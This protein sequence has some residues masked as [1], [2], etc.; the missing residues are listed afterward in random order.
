V[1]EE[2]HVAA[3]GLGAGVHLA[4]AAPAGRDHP[5]LWHRA[6]DGLGR[7]V[8]GPAIG[9]DHLH[10]ARLLRDGRER[11]TDARRLV[12]RGDDDTDAGTR[13]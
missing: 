12:Q 11:R 6:M 7:A 2:E 13:D 1:E 5:R 4:G 3:R 10:R 8:R 9:H